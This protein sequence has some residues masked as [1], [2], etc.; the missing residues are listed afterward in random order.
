MAGLLDRRA[1]NGD[2]KVDEP[3]LQRL[4]YLLCY[5]AGEFGWKRPT[6]TRELLCLQ[7][8]RD[9]FPRVAVCTM[10]RALAA[11]GARL[12]SPK[13]VVLCPWPRRRRLRVLAELRRLAERASAAEPVFYGDEIDIH[14]N[15]KIGRDWMLPGVQRRVVTPG[16]NQK[17]YLAGALDAR[18]GKLLFVDAPSKSSALFCKLLWRLATTYRH[19]PSSSTT[20]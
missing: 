13:P 14:L 17:H 12:G 5:T 7:M 8:Q 4:R 9:G 20:S 16:K 3:F 2:A 6:W 15:P 1:G 10:G 11:I 19:A 18:T